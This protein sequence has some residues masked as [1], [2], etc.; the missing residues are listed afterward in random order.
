ML[1]VPEVAA[2]P[3]LVEGCVLPVVIEVTFVSIVL[4][5]GAVPVVL[6]VF[7]VRCVFEGATVSTGVSASGTGYGV[8]AV[9]FA[10]AVSSGHT[11]QFP[12]PVMWLFAES[13]LVEH[14]GLS[15][16]VGA[17]AQFL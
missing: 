10:P 3:A 12:L 7:E 4:R 2:V 6:V 13:V 9:V 14:H 1:L 11:P 8:L 17:G 15:S 16:S 5:V